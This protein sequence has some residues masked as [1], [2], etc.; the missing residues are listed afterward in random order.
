[1]PD[2]SMP[3]GDEPQAP[4]GDP[5]PRR[6]SGAGSEQ[7][8]GW[9]ERRVTEMGWGR[10]P[11]FGRPEFDDRRRCW[12]VPVLAPGGEPVGHVSVDA[13]TGG[14]RPDMSTGAAVMESRWQAAMEKPGADAAADPAQTPADAPQ[15]ANKLLLGDSE[16]TLAGL[17]DGSV[18]LV[19]TSPPY[20]NARPGYAEWAD[21]AG[22]LA[23]IGRVLA[24][25]GRILADGRFMAVNSAPVLEPRS[26]RA[27]SSTRRPVPFDLHGV[28]SATG[29]FEFVDDIVW[30]KPEG[31]GW[32]T[33][34]GRRF[35]AD[36]WPLQYKPAPVTEYVLVYRKRSG[37]LID[38]H[39]REH[40]ERHPDPGSSKI[41]DGYERTNLWRIQP[42]SDPEHPAVFPAGLAERVIR[43]WSFQG[44]AVCDP[45]AGTGTV[46]E[47]SAALGR[48][49]VLSEISADYMD[50]IKRNAVRWLGRE[51]ENVECVG[52][53]P[54][55]SGAM[56]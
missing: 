38:R 12:R 19:F 4:I 56:L 1:M 7:A 39:I 37:H 11:R 35:S 51:A 20:Y 24:Q 14:L 8:L 16:H 23:K 42:A 49:F 17:P 34:R 6:R 22:Y 46:G 33:G 2:V 3:L 9:A 53:D 31:A 5:G 29:M 52:T 48:R 30:A 43:Y 28:V 18:G 13:A 45:F 55:W 40:Q 21:Y 32:A 36:R 25:C 10:S 41:P 27:Q 26:D 15:S 50:I 54:I 44:D 47:A